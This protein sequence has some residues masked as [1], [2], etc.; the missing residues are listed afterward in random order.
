ML[1]E[2]AQNAQNLICIGDVL[3]LIYFEV[4]FPEPAGDESRII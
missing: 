4:E 1:F 2:I 3:M